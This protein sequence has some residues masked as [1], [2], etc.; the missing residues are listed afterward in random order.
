M[1]SHLVGRELE[2]T[3]LHQWLDKAR[4]GERQLVFVTGEP[5][6]GKTALI[7]AFLSGVR[8]SKEF[9]VEEKEESQKSKVKGQKSK[10]PNLSP[11][12]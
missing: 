7:E 4:N 3:Q 9:A 5:G 12:P 11:S 1:P 2:L 8:S 6:I 10:I